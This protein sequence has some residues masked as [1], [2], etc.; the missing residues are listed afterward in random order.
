MTSIRAIAAGALAL[1]L[2]SIAPALAQEAGTPTGPTETKQYDDWM[3]RC[4]PVKS[5]SPCDMFEMLANKQTKQRMM[6]LSIAYVPK[7][8]GNV[9]QIAVPLGVMIQKGLVLATDSYTS[10]MLHFRRCDRGGCYVEMIMP[11]D[12][13]SALSAATDSKI[14]IYADGGKVYNI[15]FTIKGFNE[16]HGAMADLARKKTNASPA[17][18]APDTPAPAPDNTPSP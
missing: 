7:S 17:P 4:F 6:S 10:P 5:P 13:V 16:A 2:L 15:P 11:P 8:D 9:I 18:A 14:T 1:G 3:V 12:M